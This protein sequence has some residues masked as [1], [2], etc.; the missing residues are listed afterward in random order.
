M[1]PHRSILI[2]M[3]TPLAS[4]DTAAIHLYSKIDTLWYRAPF[5]FGRKDSTLRFYE[6]RADWQPGR[7]YSLE[8]DSAAFVDIYGLVSKE[9]KQGIKVKSLDEYSTLVMQT[10]GIQ[11]TAIVVQLLDKSEPEEVYYYHRSIECKAKWDNTLQ[12]N[13]TER[14]RN[15]Q[16][17]GELVK[18]KNSKNKKKQMNRNADRAKRLG[19]EYVK[20]NTIKVKNNESN[21]SK[22]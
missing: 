3:P 19:I 9:F 21:N 20:Q 15:L 2:E 12:W 1:D 11:D 16:K 6:F 8:I 14:K 13:M 5:D 7:E 4:L 22:K 10:S 18:Q 17:P